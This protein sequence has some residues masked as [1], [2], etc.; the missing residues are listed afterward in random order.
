MDNMVWVTYPYR[1]RHIEMAR[2]LL[3]DRHL[4]QL[5]YSLFTPQVLILRN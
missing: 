2:D 3:A 4:H 1:H 5:P